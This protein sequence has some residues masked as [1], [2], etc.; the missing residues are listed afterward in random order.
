[1]PPKDLLLSLIQRHSIRTAYTRFYTRREARTRQLKSS[2]DSCGL[3]NVKCFFWMKRYQRRTSKNQQ[4]GIKDGGYEPS[5]C[6]KYIAFLKYAFFIKATPYWRTKHDLG[7]YISYSIGSSSNVVFGC[8][9]TRLIYFR[10]WDR[11]FAGKLFSNSLKKL[12]AIQKNILY[13]N[14]RCSK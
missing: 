7:N 3:K 13:R 9:T 11:G 12:W 10:S 8:K 2:F 6:S 14:R 5:E 1:M 4:H